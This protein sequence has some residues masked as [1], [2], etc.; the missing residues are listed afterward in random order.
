MCGW[1]AFDLRICV[2]FVAFAVRCTKCTLNARRMR[3]ECKKQK[4][5]PGGL[6]IRVHPRKSSEMQKMRVKRAQN[7][8]QMRT[9]CARM[10]VAKSTQNSSKNYTTHTYLFTGRR[11]PRWRGFARR[12]CRRVPA[13]TGRARNGPPLASA[14]GLSRRALQQPL[15]AQQMVHA[16]RAE[17]L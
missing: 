15:L 12:G 17:R 5:P 8:Q 7:A 4:P 9:E 2:H 16:G 14:L 1:R 11:K 6:C 10:P 13:G 3:L